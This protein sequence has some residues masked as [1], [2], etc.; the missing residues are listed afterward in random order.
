MNIKKF[1]ENQ[2][3]CL[4]IFI[5]ILEVRIYFKYFSYLYLLIGKKGMQIVGYECVDNCVIIKAGADHRRSG[6]ALLA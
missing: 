6:L 2:Q 3:F 1:S 5:F 4:M